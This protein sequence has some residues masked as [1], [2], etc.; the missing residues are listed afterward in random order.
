MRRL[1]PKI[2]ALVA[3]VLCLSLFQPY[4]PTLQAASGVPSR[5][6]PAPFPTAQHLKQLAESEEELAYSL[7]IQAY[8]YGYPLVISAKTM[9]EMTQ[10]RA[11]INQFYYSE[12]LASPAYRDIVTPNSDTLYMN[13]WLDLSQ[14][15]VILNVPDNPQNRY[16]TVQMLDVYTNTFR[17]VSNRSTKQKAGR[18]LIAG[19]RWKGIV[20]ANTSL[21]QTPTGTVWLVGRVEVKGDSDLP[22]AIRFEKQIT[23]APLLQAKQASAPQVSAAIPADALTSL[24]FFKIMTDMICKNPPPACDRVLLDQFALAGIDVE[25]GFTPSKLRPATLAGLRRAL[26]EAPGIVQNGFPPYTHIRNGWGSFSPI[27]TYGNQFLAR[28]FIAFSGLAANVPEEEVYYRAYTDERGGL[29][30]GTKRYTLHFTKEQLPQTPAF[31]SINVYSHQLYLATTAANRSSVRSNTGTLVYN[32]D[33][34]LDLYIQ[35]E[36]PPGKESNWIPTPAGDF[37]LVLRVFAPAPDP[38]RKDHAW[39]PVYESKS[40]KG[41]LEVLKS[42]IPR[43]FISDS[44]RRVKSG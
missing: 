17:N 18:Y 32:P 34:S 39:P 33:G 36:P 42:A 43:P 27:G 5:S 3:W 16:Y 21:I 38:W 9:G 25:H 35:K 40:A 28:A 20:P 6:A 8:I 30:T 37:N 11:P 7:G 31:W 23:L 22:Q 29:L 4:A 12:T 19:P 13:A 15:P 2:I 14:S 10:S 24:S 41:V 26:L 44:F 1:S